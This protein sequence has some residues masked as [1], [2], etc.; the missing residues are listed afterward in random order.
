LTTELYV[1]DCP[2]QEVI[3]GLY[4][5][6]S[7]PQASSFG[8]VLTQT[9]EGFYIDN[10]LNPSICQINTV[11]VDWFVDIR[12]NSV[13]LTQYQFLTTVGPSQY[14]T[15]SQWVDA[16]QIALGGLLTS[17]YSYNIDEDN[18]QV[19]VFNNNCQPNFDDIQINVGL[20][21]DIYCNG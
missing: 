5:W 10:G 19:I 7:D 11:V 4:P 8:V 21:F 17:G 9:L 1:Y 6:N 15:S 14:P 3:C 12:I 13:I 16:L 18:E 20:E 2:V